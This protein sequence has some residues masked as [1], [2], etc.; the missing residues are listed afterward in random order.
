MM[1]VTFKHALVAVIVFCVT[2]GLLKGVE[3]I[4]MRSV[5]RTPLIRAMETVPGIKTASMMGNDAVRLVLKPQANLM[6]S[7]Q[8][9][10]S[11]AESSL[12]Q[13]PLTVTIAEHPNT[14]MTNVANQA[15]F[16][17]AQGIATGQYVTMEHSIVGLASKS[18]LNAVVQIDATH[19]YLTLTSDHGTFYWYHVVPIASSPQ[20]GALS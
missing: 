15:Q 10:V 17:V 9:V 18:G 5:V 3:I 14:I 11:D 6:S 1:K 4:Y 7:Y 12:G 19:V 20:K 8:A 2:L 16:M 13:A